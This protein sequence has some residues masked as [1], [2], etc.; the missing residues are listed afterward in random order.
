MY[1]KHQF[2]DGDRAENRFKEICIKNGYSIKESS[3]NENVQKHIDVYI[4]KKI[5]WFGVDI[6][7]KKRISRNNPT[8][9]SKYIWIEFKNVN[10]RVGWIYGKADYVAFELD[11]GFILVKRK[12]LALFAEKTVDFNSVV[13]KAEEAIYKIYTRKDKK[14]QISLIL[15]SDLYKLNHIILK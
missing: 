4:Q 9:Q 11:E 7:A 6:K 10:G 5:R 14:D 1:R 15:S 2:E 12:E 13:N 8:P 3:F